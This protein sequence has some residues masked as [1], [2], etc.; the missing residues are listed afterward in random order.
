MFEGIVLIRMQLMSLFQ[1]FLDFRLKRP[2]IYLLKRSLCMT[3]LE[4]AS[5]N[6][7]SE[8]DCLDM[9]TWSTF[10]GKVICLGY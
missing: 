1:T 6:I 7:H 5:L 4:T 3:G 2:N 10:C 8:N 9:C